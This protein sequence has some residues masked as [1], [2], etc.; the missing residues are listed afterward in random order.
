MKMIKRM[1]LPLLLILLFA[2]G[3]SSNGESEVKNAE[4]LDYG[5]V[6]ELEQTSLG[7]NSGVINIVSKLAGGEIPHKIEISS[8]TLRINYDLVKYNED[9]EE[10]AEYWYNS[11]NQ[12]RNAGLNSAILFSLVD[13]LNSVEV[14]FNGE[15]NE[16][17]EFSREALAGT[18]DTTF[19]KLDEG[20]FKEYKRSFDNE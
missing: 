20:T 16:Q 18:L 15:T 2:A 13:N 9:N 6:S 19:D 11:G 7:N 1:T 5:A 4:T 12:E 3:C 8:D 17:Y 14:A 10:N